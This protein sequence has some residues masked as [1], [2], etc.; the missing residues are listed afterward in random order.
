MSNTSR[1]S[2][3]T[4]GNAW[5]RMPSHA[6]W[7]AQSDAGIPVASRNARNRTRPL[8][9]VKGRLRPPVTGT[10]VRQSGEKDDEG[11]PLEGIVLRTKPRAVVIAPFDSG[12]M[13]AG[14]HDDYGKLLILSTGGGYHFVLAG[15]TKIY[16]VEGQKLLEGEPVGV[17][18]VPAEDVQAMNAPRASGTGNASSANAGP[19][20]YFEI[21]ENGKPIDPL[22]WLATARLERTSQ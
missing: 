7:G 14:D 12:I 21:R 6:N 1:T 15:M 8:E 3:R 19:G 17:M 9:D 4:L 16:G 13:V 11:R 5:L 2:S 10:I 18:G 22:P 20:L